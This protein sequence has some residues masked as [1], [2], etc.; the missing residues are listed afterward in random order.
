MSYML[1]IV[2]PTGQ[3]AERG[4]EGGKQVYGRMVQFSADLKTRGVLLA[5]ESLASQDRGTRVQVCAGRS[6]LVDGPFA[7]AKEMIG[8]TPE[9]IQAI[10]PIK[11]GVIADF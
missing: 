4:L 3:R 9:N 11:D 6:T 5:T 7:E 10:R 8:K 1:L 2:E